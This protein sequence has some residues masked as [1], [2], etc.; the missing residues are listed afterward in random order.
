MSISSG[1]GIEI[2]DLN[3]DLGYLFSEEL[4]LVLEINNGILNE[5]TNKLKKINVN[6]NILGKTID[7]K[8]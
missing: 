8:K 4:G 1:I 2:E 5:L 6:F 3:R 7:N